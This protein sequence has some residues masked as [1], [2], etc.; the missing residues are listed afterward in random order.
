MSEFPPPKY[1]DD[2][3]CHEKWS[4]AAQVL[5]GP[6]GSIKIEFW[7]FRWTHEVPVH[8]DR[9]GPVARVAM[10]VAA[11]T[12]LRDKLTAALSDLHQKAELAQAAPAS[13]TKN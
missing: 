12:D 8:C 7:V 11:A 4:E 5:Q 13:P 3:T 1:I 10:T 2:V 9:I 6:I